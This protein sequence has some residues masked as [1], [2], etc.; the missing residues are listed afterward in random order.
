MVPLQTH[1]FR[2]LTSWMLQAWSLIHISS[3]LAASRAEWN[4][5][6]NGQQEAV[7]DGAVMQGE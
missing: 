1:T 6:I 3:L 7:K 2:V 5:T 4:L